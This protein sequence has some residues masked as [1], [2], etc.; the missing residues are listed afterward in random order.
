MKIYMKLF[1]LDITN[2]SNDI[3]TSVSSLRGKV[4]F[5]DFSLYEL[6]PIVNFLII[7]NFS[8]NISTH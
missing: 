4:F 2:T 8:Y 7:F 1:K 5:S 6:W 3:D